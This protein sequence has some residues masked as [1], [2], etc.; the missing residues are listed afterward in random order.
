MSQYKYNNNKNIDKATWNRNEL[1]ICDVT[2]SDSKTL[3]Q[4]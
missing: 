3:K 4:K 2:R 1:T